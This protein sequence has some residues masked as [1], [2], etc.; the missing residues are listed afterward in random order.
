MDKRESGRLSEQETLLLC[1]EI[2]DR[3]IDHFSREGGYLAENLSAVRR[4]SNFD[5]FSMTTISFFSAAIIFLMHRRSF[6]KTD[7]ASLSMTM[8]RW[9]K[10]WGS[11]HPERSCL[12]QDMSS[13]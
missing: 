6:A 13:M 12:R 7:A 11:W 5:G 9:R 1:Q 10:R 2:R 4:L 8:S 3:M